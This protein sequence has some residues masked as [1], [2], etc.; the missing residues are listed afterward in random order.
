MH[1]EQVQAGQHQLYKE[2]GI[3]FSHF[4]NP[5]SYYKRVKEE[6]VLGFAGMEKDDSKNMYTALQTI[7]LITNIFTWNVLLRVLGS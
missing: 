7:F 5:E 6:L 1:F 3:S 4:A 2:F